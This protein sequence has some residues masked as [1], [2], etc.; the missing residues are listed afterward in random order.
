M[1]LFDAL[2]VIGDDTASIYLDIEYEDTRG[3][4]PNVVIKG[5]DYT[6][7]SRDTLARRVTRIGTKSDGSIV[8]C[9]YKEE[10]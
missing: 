1:N 9:A 3:V 6:V 5:Y 7:L 10:G 4:V 8:I 2:N